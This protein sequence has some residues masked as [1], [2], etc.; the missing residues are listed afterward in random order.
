[1]QISFVPL[2]MQGQSSPIV[3]QVRK[4]LNVHG[5]NELDPALCEIVRGVQRANGLD[6]HG[7]L[8]ERTLDLFGI[9]AY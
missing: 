4:A 7:D 8:D 3:A 2:V 6:P 9:T 1:M 5:G